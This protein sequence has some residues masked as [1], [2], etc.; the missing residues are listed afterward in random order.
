MSTEFLAAISGAIV[1]GLIAFAIQLIVLR[2]ARKQRDEETRERQQA[3]GQALLIKMIKIHSTLFG[4]HRQ[5]E[6][7]FENASNPKLEPWEF[8]LPL[9]N[10]P[11][12]VSFSTDEMSLFLSLKNN[13]LFNSILHMD[14]IHNTTIDSFRTYREL[15]ASLTSSL[16]AEMEG[17]VGTTNFTK[18][19][20]D[21]FRPK[22]V[23]INQL[24]I[25]L[26]ERC[27][28]DQQESWE[29]LEALNSALR[30][31]IGLKYKLEHKSK[32]VKSA[33]D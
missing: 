5:L 25:D 33:S 19:Q 2:Q 27:N 9:A 31:A 32:V 26:R 24:A 1:G 22:M 4:M 10:L 28:I 11:Q 8:V 30:N 7:F 14:E 3:I 6:D 20:Y 13:G 23:E 29:V 15:R 12:F 17:I 18:P 16:A 21:F